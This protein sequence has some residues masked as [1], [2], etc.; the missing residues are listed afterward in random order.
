MRQ[1]ETESCK[2]SHH[3][4]PLNGRNC[5]RSSVG[6]TLIEADP[7]TARSLVRSRAMA[8]FKMSWIGWGEK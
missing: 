5:S 1:G 8:Q 4:F 6:T 2:M 7:L 3:S